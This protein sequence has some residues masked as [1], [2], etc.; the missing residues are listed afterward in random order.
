MQSEPEPG[1]IIFI[2]RDGSSHRKDMIEG[3]HK[4][5]GSNQIK[6]IDFHGKPLENIEGLI[7][8]SFSE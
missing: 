7:K 3:L 2:V 8:A 4:L 6:E 5:Y 1:K